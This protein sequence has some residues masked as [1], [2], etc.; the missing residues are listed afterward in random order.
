MDNTK[1]K[2][3]INNFINDERINT[4]LL[5]TTFEIYAKSNA[6]LAHSSFLASLFSPDNNGGYGDIPLKKFIKLIDKK[7]VEKNSS[8]IKNKSDK[9]LVTFSNKYIK[10]ESILFENYKLNNIEVNTEYKIKAIEANNSEYDSKSK[11]S[12]DIKIDFVYLFDDSK[13]QSFSIIIENKINAHEGENQTNNYFSIMDNMKTNSK[14]VYVYLTL[15]KPKKSPNSEF[16]VITYDELFEYV[17]EPLSS[18][19]YENT[20]FYPILLDYRRLLLKKIGKNLNKKYIGVESIK[21]DY[22]ELFDYIENREEKSDILDKFK[23]EYSDV[24]D[25]LGVKINKEK[26]VYDFCDLDLDS[27]DRLYFF[28]I[29]AYKGKPKTDVDFKTYE[30]CKKYEIY[31]LDAKRLELHINGEKITTYK[32]ASELVN[33]LSKIEN[34]ELGIINAKQFLYYKVGDKYYSLIQYRQKLLDE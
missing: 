27:D 10:E 18:R 25:M 11:K 8:N 17:I 12:I 22:K 9:S 26:D 29:G 19:K 5:P 2:E 15:F 33:Y 31:P 7:L 6:E 24:L 4:L 16:I 28:P 34:K 20:Y 23:I 14:N 21:N 30:H 13:T 3:L 1:I 32:N